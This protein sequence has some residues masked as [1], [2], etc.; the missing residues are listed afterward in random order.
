MRRI[1]LIWTALAALAVLACIAGVLTG[2]ASLGA[3]DSLHALISPD[4]PGHAVLLQ[5][6]LPRVANG[7]AVGALL[8]IAGALLQVL[9]RNPLAEPYILGLSGGAAIGALVALSLALTAAGVTGCAALGSALSLALLLIIARRE[10]R[11]VSHDTAPERLILCGVMLAALW[12]AV[13]TLA[14]S[15]SPQG[16]ISAMIFWLMGDLA[17]A[18]QG[19]FAWA[20]LVVVV[21]GAVQDA[22]RLNL[23]ARGDD[24][25]AS[26]GVNVGALKLRVVIYSALA[27]GASVA[28]AGTIGFIG[29]IAPHLVRVLWGNDQRML[30]PAA[31]LLGAA[32]VVT[33]DLLAR[34]A[35]AP[36]QLPV[37][38]VTAVVGAP[39]FLSLLLRARK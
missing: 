2:S 17:G 23:L 5:L 37:G 27:A 13:L 35:I 33:A 8:G 18:N 34:S 3:S 1:L 16:R 25:A 9:L 31:G 22:P 32:L 11:G 19:V 38:A 36:Q 39:I 15:L 12:G 10:F 21:V 24:I 4:L 20:A 29:L 28:L 7:F 26:L 14:L 30:L 6:R